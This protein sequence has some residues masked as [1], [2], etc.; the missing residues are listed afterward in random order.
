MSERS[1]FQIEKIDETQL[2]QLVDD[3]GESLPI[4]QTPAWYRFERTFPDRTFL[5]FFAIYRDADPIALIALQKVEYHGTY[6]LWAKHGPVWLVSLTPELEAQVASALVDWVKQTHPRAAFLR[7]HVD[8]GCEGT[9]PPMQ[10]VT[11]DQTVVM[12]T[13][14]GADG[15]MAGLKKR[16]RSYLRQYLRRTP[17]E[18]V[19]ETAEAISDFARFHRLMA[20]T[21]SRQSFSAWSSDVYQSMLRELGPEHA[22]LYAALLDG[23]MVAW[24]I[25]TVSGKQG[26][27]Y[28]AASSEAGR[29][30]GAPTQ[31]LYRAAIALGDQGIEEIDLMGIGSELAPSLMQLNSFKTGFAKEVSEVTP[32]R[33]L[34]ISMPRYRFL[35]TIRSG[36]R[37]LR[38]VNSRLR[39]KPNEK[40]K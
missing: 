33:D 3:T 35:T 10:I 36:K 40:G 5:G 7:I 13:V 16:G 29:E 32:A 24:A 26:I 15:I 38:E 34:V 17:V 20:S 28:Y 14:G 9:H 11:Y 22:R 23:E 2:R 30:V 12:S 27:Y 39:G 31:I 25:F 18:V 1:T 4:E 37:V 19:D 6:F 8:E 21:A